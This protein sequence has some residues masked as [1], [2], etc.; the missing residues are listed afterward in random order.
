[1][2]KVSLEQWRMFKSVV[3]FGGFNQASAGIH[4]SQSSIH[5]AINKLE[6]LLGVKLFRI[7]GRKTRLTEAGELMLRRANF[8]LDEAGKVETVAANL[9]KGIESTLRIAVDEIFPQHLL[10]QVLDAVSDEFPLLRIELMETVLNGATELLENTDVDIAVSPVT[11]KK[12]FYEEL[13]EI[14]F[15]A[16]ASPEHPLHNIKPQLSLQDL[17]SHRQIVVRDSSKYNKH[18]DGWLEAEQRWTVSHLNTSIN[19]INKGLGFAWLPRCLITNELANNRLKP[20]NLSHGGVR[21]TNLY[22]LFRDADGLG[23]AAR[24]FLGELRYQSM[25]LPVS[26]NRLIR[27][28]AEQ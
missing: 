25:N 20:L 10:Y 28:C 27:S 18:N 24:A 8:L 12:L 3:E 22:L 1:M 7:E 5:N 19:I 4:K 23:P 13:C 26:E 11:V 15:I 14:E 21:K 16:V 6:G 17:K 2:L 9:A